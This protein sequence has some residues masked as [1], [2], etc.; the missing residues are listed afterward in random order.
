MSTRLQSFALAFTCALSLPAKNVLENP[1]FDH[2]ASSWDFFIPESS[3]DHG[4]T[5]SIAPAEGMNGGPAAQVRSPVN[6][7]CG[8]GQKNIPIT[9][10]T[11][12]KVTFW[13]KAEEG[14]EYKYGPVLRLN[15]RSPADEGDTDYYVGL[16]GQVATD[17]KQIKRPDLLPTAWEKVE[18]VVE[19]PINAKFLSLCFFSWGVQGAVYF[20]DLSVE[21]IIPASK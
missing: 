6:S 18:A 13:V 10:W 17:I 19:S 20:D 5:F 1:G 7:R 16:G 14:I 2:G 4:N 12:Y 8:I 9:G 21:P 3:K 11:R 15:F